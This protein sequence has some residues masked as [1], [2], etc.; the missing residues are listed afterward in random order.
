MS[1]EARKR[2][3]GV[4]GVVLDASLF[5]AT[6]SSAITHLERLLHRLSYSHIR[7]GILFRKGYNDESC[8][9]QK[10]RIE[11][12]MPSGH[13][14]DSKNTSDDRISE[15]LNELSLAWELHV[16]ECVFLTPL[17][18][19]PLKSNLVSQGWHI[20]LPSDSTDLEGLSDKTICLIQELYCQIA[21]IS[22]DVG[23]EVIIAGYSMKW[24][25]ELDFLKRG[26]LPIH[27]TNKNLCFLPVNV[28][29]SM[30]KQFEI[31]DIM[32]HK[33][34]DE[35]ASVAL[36]AQGQMQDQVIFTDA[37][38]RALRHL[39]S[40]PQIC[41]VDPVERILP[42]VDRE[43][44]QEILQG[45]STLERPS[46]TRIRA[47][48]YKRVL[49]F[50]NVDPLGVLKDCNLLLPVIVKPQMACGISH[51]HTMAVVFKEEGFLNLAVPVP[52]TIQEYIDHGSRLYKFYIIGEKVF[53]S[54]RKSTPNAA[55]LTGSASD[56]N[57]PAA[58]VFDSLKS[59]P[60]HFIE[61]DKAISDHSL[62]SDE[63]DDG[64]DFQLVFA[65]AAWLR[66][67]LKLTIFGFDV[68]IEMNSNDHVIIDVNYFPTFKDID[69]QKSIP[70]FWDAL[71]KAYTLHKES[72][73]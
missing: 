11:K 8:A 34:T 61:D 44:T 28:E 20:C 58:I 13:S 70:A 17:L 48:R 9:I 31:L 62:P 1:M 24:S 63:T 43:L 25:R 22:K 72:Q 56:S 23:D 15:V 37:M 73:A 10:E 29:V 39:S 33:P 5:Y 57:I 2:R 40:H 65:A 66:E 46:S 60:K 27:I 42:L 36:G 14:F 64:L 12:C 71:L 53:Y 6:S 55:K 21:H 38:Q 51:A 52:S 3:G 18:E 41:V 16:S 30:C 49:S 19:A 7:L 50:Q 59:L 4:E 35:I 69:D 26:A 67:K 32:L 68:V 47:P 45:L 54:T